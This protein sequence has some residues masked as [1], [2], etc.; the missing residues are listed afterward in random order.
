LNQAGAVRTWVIAY[1]LVAGAG[2]GSLVGIGCAVKANFCPWR[3]P[4]VQTSTDG[5]LLFANNCAVC[6][7]ADLRG[8][9]NAP[10]LVTG[11]A[12]GYSIDELVN[13]ISR[14]KPLAGMPRFRKD[15][16]QQQIRAVAE[17]IVAQRGG[18]G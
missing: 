15:L 8:R 12:A 16:T 2:L 3:K 9:K 14:G 18:T 17:Y 13:K 1:I 5:K 4:P 11:P 6:H 7:G 10:S